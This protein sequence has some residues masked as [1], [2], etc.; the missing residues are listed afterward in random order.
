MLASMLRQQRTLAT[1]AASEFACCYHCCAS[2]SLYS[3]PSSSCSSLYFPSNRSSPPPPGPPSAPPPLLPSY[4]LHSS[5]SSPL[6]ASSSSSFSVG[7]SPRS[8][9]PSAQIS[10]RSLH[11]QEAHAQGF[12][13]QYGVSVP[14]GCLANTA[15][16]AEH[17]AKELGEDIDYVIK[18]QVLAGGRGLGYFSENGFQGG[19]H[20]CTSASQVK[21]IAGKMLGN[22][23]VT[24]QTGEQGKLC[25]KVLVCERFYLR[26]EKYLAL[27]MDRNSGGP[28]F[29][30]SVVGGTSIEDIAARHP[31]AIVHMPVD[32]SKQELGELEVTEFCTKLG[33]AGASLSQAIANVRGIY[34]LFNEKDCTLIEINPFAE[35]HDGR[36][37]ACD[38]KLNFDDNAAYR[39]EEVF[40]LRDIEQEDPRE[41]AASRYDLNYVGLDGSIGCMVNGA[42]LAMATMD[43]I[44]LHGGRPANFLDVGGGANKQQVV[45]A[46][47]ILQ[48]D[49]NVKAIMVNIFGGIMRCDIIGLGIIH[50]SQEVGLYKPLVVRLEGTNQEKARE[51]LEESGMKVMFC[52][53]FDDAARKVVKMAE[54]VQLA[55]HAELDVS[56]AM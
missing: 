50:A 31:E 48:N 19:V 33:F 28:L 36:V 13:A 9:P 1:S 11:L 43:I 16:E 44:K 20:V 25:S 37:L 54:I 32:S 8:P 21:D 12:L 3:S 17:C 51:L 22:H 14:R 52:T 41:V 27:L 45:E 23:L 26:R 46:L 18:A 53:D 15:R 42:G 4:P 5:S 49:P 7:R 10:I 34:K 38:A 35:T 40:A 2:A 56:F 24:K 29:I 39:Q 30:G 55:E 47:R 6:F